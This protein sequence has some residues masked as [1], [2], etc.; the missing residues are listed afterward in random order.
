MSHAVAIGNVKIALDRLARGGIN[1]TVR[2]V[3]RVSHRE[4]LTLKGDV[5]IQTWFD[6]CTLM[7]CSAKRALVQE[8]PYVFA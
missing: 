6:L 2:S 5:R 4:H 1:M 7:R 8:W 3:Q